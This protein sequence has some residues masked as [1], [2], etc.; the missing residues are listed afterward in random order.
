MMS[1]EAFRRFLEPYIK[2]KIP[3]LAYWHPAGMGFLRLDTVEVPDRPPIETHYDYTPTHPHQLSKRGR[4]I[5]ER[6]LAILKKQS[7]GKV[8]SVDFDGENITE[9]D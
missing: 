4:K 8:V 7:Y 3:F 2:D 6:N 1:E 5:W 9:G